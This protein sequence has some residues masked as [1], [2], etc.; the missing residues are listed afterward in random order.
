MDVLAATGLINYFGKWNDVT[1]I[2]IAP[3]LIRKG[4]THVSLYGMGYMNDQR[5]SRLLRNDKVLS[6]Y[7]LILRLYYKAVT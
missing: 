1:E 7:S 5:L 4:V 3:L 6:A 2:S